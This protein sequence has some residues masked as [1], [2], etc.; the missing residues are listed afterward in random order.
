MRPN[1]LSEYQVALSVF[2]GPLDLLLHL[3]EREELEITQV[4]LAQI[5]DQYLAYLNQLEDR[6]PENLA[7]FLVIAA[8]L[9]LIKSRA[10]LPQP[11]RPLVSDREEI[12]IGEDLVQ[13]LVEYKKFK[14]A[15]RWLQEIEA[16]GFCSFVRLP[17]TLPSERSLDLGGVTLDDLV[18]AIQEVLTLK[19]PAPSVNETVPPL[20]ITVEEQMEFIDRQTTPGY[21]VSFRTLIGQAANRLEI[22]VTFLALLEM[23]KQRRVIIRQERLFGDIVII[24]KE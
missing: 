4:S 22:I 24:K 11:S 13:R 23:V 6:D 1:Y 10:L 19:P 21:P 3:I 2:E 14:E 16:Q 18:N 12:D 17:G 7:E 5:T 15:A 8:K 20:T 9:L